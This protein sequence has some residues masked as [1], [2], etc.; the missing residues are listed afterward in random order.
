MVN[1]TIEKLHLND[2]S[3]LFS[4]ATY[5]VGMLIGSLLSG[6]IVDKYLENGVHDW[7]TI[8]LIPAGIAA[9]VLLLFIVFFRDPK[10]KI[11]NQ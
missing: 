10:K 4:Q 9:V 11:Q 3:I 2:D 7:K 5:G 1:L 8:W 6:R